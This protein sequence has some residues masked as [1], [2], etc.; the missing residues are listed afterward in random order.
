MAYILIN[1]KKSKKEDFRKGQ[2]VYIPSN[3][4]CKNPNSLNEAL[5]YIT[6]IKSNGQK[7]LVKT[8]DG[9]LISGLQRGII[10][11]HANRLNNETMNIDMLQ[12]PDWQ[13]TIL[14]EKFNIKYEIFF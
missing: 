5:G 6:D 7:F 1:Q 4:M 14:P 9:K 11:T 13:D 8:L 10:D 2:L 3:L 12:L